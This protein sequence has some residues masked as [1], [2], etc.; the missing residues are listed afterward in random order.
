MEKKA[1]LPVLVV[2][3]AVISSVFVVYAVSEEKE[4]KTD[5]P[6]TVSLSLYEASERIPLSCQYFE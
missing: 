4:M 1:I 6:P 5:L 3:L 2:T